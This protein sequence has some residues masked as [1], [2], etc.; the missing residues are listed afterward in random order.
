MTPILTLPA[1]KA[2]QG[3]L[4]SLFRPVRRSRGKRRMKTGVRGD[5]KGK[6]H[7][8]SVNLQQLRLSDQGR[9][10]QPGTY[11]KGG[12]GDRVVEGK[13]QTDLQSGEWETPLGTAVL[14]L[15]GG[16]PSDGERTR[17]T[18]KELA[19]SGEAQSSDIPSLQH[20]YR[21]NLRFGYWI[22][23]SL[24]FSCTFTFSFCKRYKT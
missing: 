2:E 17:D 1:Y 9:I 13:G 20:L 5:Q 8:R 14:A 10:S 18:R 3:C 21:C 23:M 12:G 16:K 24:S 19:V 15:S 22:V 11:D 7:W 6:S 4:P